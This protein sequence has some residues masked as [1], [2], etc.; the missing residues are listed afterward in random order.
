MA[1]STNKSIIDITAV[2]DRMRA[3][4]SIPSKYTDDIDLMIWFLNEVVETELQR[5]A[6]MVCDWI[7]GQRHWRLRM[8]HD[9]IPLLH[10]M[11]RW[12]A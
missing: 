7:N 11:L 2:K 8:S 3:G 10:K 1:R 12:N 6:F 5:S 9:G 4:E